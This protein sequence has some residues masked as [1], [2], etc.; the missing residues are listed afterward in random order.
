MRPLHVPSVILHS[1][2]QAALSLWRA[3]AFSALAVLTLALGI[4]AAVAV[5]AV[6]K[7]VLLTLVLRSE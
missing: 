1:L 4:A 2:G 3:P 6:T 5:F 7:T